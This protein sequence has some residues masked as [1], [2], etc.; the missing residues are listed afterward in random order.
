MFPTG[1]EVSNQV[2]YECALLC[3]ESAASVVTN[4]G[5]YQ[6]PLASHQRLIKTYKGNNPAHVFC[7]RLCH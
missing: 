4:V 5:H 6:Q 7:V 2:Q 3:N 1:L